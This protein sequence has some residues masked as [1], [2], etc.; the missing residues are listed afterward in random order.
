LIHVRQG[1]VDLVVDFGVVLMHINPIDGAQFER[2][3]LGVQ[4]DIH[5]GTHLR[6]YYVIRRNESDRFLQPLLEGRLGSLDARLDHIA[7]H[8]LQTLFQVLTELC[9]RPVEVSDER[10]QSVQFPK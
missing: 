7:S 9:V 8:Q 3:V 2:L 5:H 1:L 10:L 4:D 6:R